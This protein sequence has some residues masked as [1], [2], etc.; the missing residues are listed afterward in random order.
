MIPLPVMRKDKFKVDMLSNR[1]PIV[2]S[3]KPMERIENCE[4]L[5]KP[6]PIEVELRGKLPPFD[7]DKELNF[8]LLRN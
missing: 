7:I 1:Y 2:K 6:T 4:G 8:D 3:K 5:L